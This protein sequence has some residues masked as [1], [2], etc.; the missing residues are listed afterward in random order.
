QNYAIAYLDNVGG[1]GVSVRRG[2]TFSEG[3]FGENSA[4]T[5]IN[6]S[7]LL[8]AVNDGILYYYVNNIFVGQLDVGLAEGQVGNAVV[9]FATIRTNCQFRNTWVWQWD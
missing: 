1:Y 5:I 3:I 6:E 9:N 4:W 8:I 7:Q 2:D